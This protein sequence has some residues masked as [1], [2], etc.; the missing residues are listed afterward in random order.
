MGANE[1]EEHR[2]GGG[3]QKEAV[4]HHLQDPLTTAVNGQ[5]RADRSWR[6]VVRG[7]HAVED[8]GDPRP[9]TAGR[10]IQARAG[11][12]Q[13]VA[14]SQSVWPMAVIWLG[15]QQPRKVRCAGTF[16]RVGYLGERSGRA[17]SWL[18]Q[19]RPPASPRRRRT[20]R[21][22]SGRH[23]APS[24]GRVRPDVCRRGRRWRQACRSP[25]LIRASWLLET[26]LPSSEVVPRRWWWSTAKRA[27]AAAGPNSPR[28]R[29][30]SVRRP[31][32]ATGCIARSGQRVAAHLCTFLEAGKAC[33]PT[34]S[35]AVDHHGAA[36]D[37]GVRCDQ[38]PGSRV[39]ALALT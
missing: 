10:R 6:A 27:D 29:H 25:P 39:G 5:G 19:L 36:R 32:L 34:R 9:S 12:A 35:A 22:D 2:Q 33:R 14:A 21:P 24:T 20:V 30:D 18:G 17:R 31:V 37:D 11:A 38:R 15:A 8:V 3:S 4:S 23:G 1:I 7:R 28:R 26:R 16:G 13:A